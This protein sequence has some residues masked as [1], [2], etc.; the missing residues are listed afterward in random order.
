MQMVAHDTPMIAAK[1]ATV[2]TT[3]PTPKK[4]RKKEKNLERLKGRGDVWYFHKVVNGKRIFNGRKTPFSLGT[5]DIVVARAKRDAI[6]R[7]GDGA[8]IDRV[9][10]RT[11]VKCATLQQVA[12]ALMAA[13]W[14]R[15][16]TRQKYVRSLKLILRKAMG[17]MPNLSALTVDDLTA[18]VVQDFQDAVVAAVRAEG[19]E[20]L[21][22]EMMQAKYSANRALCQARSIFASEKPFRKLHLPKPEGFLSCDTFKVKRDLRYKPMSEDE[23]ALFDA[24]AK[25]IR[26]TQPGVY[27]QFLCMR[28]LGM[29]NSE[30]LACKPAEWLE[31]TPQGWVMRIT[32]RPYFLVKGNGSVRDLPVVEWLYEE[33]T[34][35]SKGREWLLPGD[36]LH[37]RQTIANREINQ[38]MRTVYETAIEE[39]KLPEDTTIRTAYD[40]RKQAGSALYQQIKDILQVSKWLGHMSVQ[41]TTQWYLGL[42]KQLPSL[43]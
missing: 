17:R 2:L 35:L 19:H 18:A 37:Q 42:I 32:N 11:Q 3:N 34:T 43:A 38:W 12:D 16:P 40:W 41:V 21:S 10:G 6:L 13:D 23:V 36:N 24:A 15:K 28:W 30:V 22:E 20:D 33:L 5:T 4:R 27:L 1:Q 8:E 39:G 25:K 14:P 29:R 7:A 9:L 31:S 26:D